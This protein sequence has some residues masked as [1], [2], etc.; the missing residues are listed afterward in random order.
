MR[1]LR[2]G[3]GRDHRVAVALNRDPNAPMLL[4][5]G[6]GARR[7]RRG[8]ADAGAARATIPPIGLVEVPEPVGPG[9]SDTVTDQR[10][11]FSLDLS[12][13]LR[14]HARRRDRA[15]VPAD[16][17]VRFCLFARRV[18]R[19]RELL[20][21]RLEGGLAARVGESLDLFGQRRQA[22]LAVARDRQV[23]FVAAPEVPVIGLHVKIAAA[24]RDD[25]RARLE[26]W[27]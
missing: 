18:M 3:P 14:A 2:Q 1:G 13:K 17:R 12:V 19:L 27:P 8:V 21:A 22:R 23:D 11:V 6:R 24:E 16:G 26:I 25:L 20:A 10:P 15:R 5:S 7:C 4:F 9:Y